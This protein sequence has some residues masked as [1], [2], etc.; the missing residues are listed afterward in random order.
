MVDKIIIS[1]E[2]KVSWLSVIPSNINWEV[3]LFLKRHLFFCVSGIINKNTKFIHKT[4]R[5]ADPKDIRND[6]VYIGGFLYA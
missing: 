5:N 1:V 3:F 4:K 6:N 2:I